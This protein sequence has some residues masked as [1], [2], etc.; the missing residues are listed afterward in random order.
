M[1]RHYNANYAPMML[2]K[3]NQDNAQ[4]F[5]YT[6]FLSL[7]MERTR[8]KARFEQARAHCLQDSGIR[9]RLDSATISLGDDSGENFTDAMLVVELPH[10]Q[11]IPFEQA[12]QAVLPGEDAAD[13]RVASRSTQAQNV[14]KEQADVGRRIAQLNDYRD[15]LI[16]LSKRA[17]VH[18]DDLIKIQSEL[19]SVQ[20]Q[21][22]QLSSQARDV[23]ERVNR[24]QLTVALGERE[25]LGDAFRPIGRVWR[26]SV[27]LIASSAADAL[28]FLIQS[29]PWL[30]IA[31]GAFFLLSWLWRL[32]RRRGT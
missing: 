2:E 23:N 7:E 8:I 27:F 22:E 21:L 19:S 5:A 24:E 10:D 20:S 29:I 28:R 9:C 13:V 18:V 6:H 25:T 11:I 4:I 30:P 15:R 14:A 1:D 16:A 31:A 17:D 3:P 32:V 26:E 12:L